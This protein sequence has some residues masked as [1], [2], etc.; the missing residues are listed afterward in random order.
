MSDLAESISDM[1]FWTFLTEEAGRRIV[2]DAETASTT[3]TVDDEEDVKS[4]LTLFPGDVSRERADDF[5][6]VKR[7]GQKRGL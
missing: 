2:G 1:L 5:F 3:S 4:S 6:D 7:P